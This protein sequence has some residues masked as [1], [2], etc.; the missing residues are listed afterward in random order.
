MHE[1]AG[2]WH[3]AR[4]KGGIVDISGDGGGEA[5]EGRGERLYEVSVVLKFWYFVF[6][7]GRGKEVEVLGVCGRLGLGGVLEGGK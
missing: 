4:I 6:C 2:S 7:I 3:V 1:R 5:V